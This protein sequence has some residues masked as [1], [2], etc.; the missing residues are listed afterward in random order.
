MAKLQTETPERA[1]RR[2][3]SKE[4]EEK[5]V[6]REMVTAF[7]QL[8]A[9]RA[10]PTKEIWRASSPLPSACLQPAC[11]LSTC[12]QASKTTNACAAQRVS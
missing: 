6:L 7:Q 12:V 11:L 4:P 2:A 3:A 9:Y 1:A 8:E 10:M 5:G